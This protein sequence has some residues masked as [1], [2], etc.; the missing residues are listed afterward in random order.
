VTA[1]VQANV[2]VGGSAQLGKGKTAK[3]STST[4]IVSPGALSKFTV[5]FPAKLRT[6]LKQTPT[7]KKVTV[8]LSA[9]A[10]GATTTN[11]TVK[12]KGQE[13]PPPHHKSKA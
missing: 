1:S 10:P 11:L 5:L 3:L 6:A 8:S 13:K 4:Q 7:S 2:T 9:S 12:V